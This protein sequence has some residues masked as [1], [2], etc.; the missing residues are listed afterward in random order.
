VTVGKVAPAAAELMD[1]TVYVASNETGVGTTWT[2]EY[3][4]DETYQ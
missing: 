2:K 1:Y 3:S 4:F